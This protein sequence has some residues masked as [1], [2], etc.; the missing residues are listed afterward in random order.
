[1]QE[2]TLEIENIK[3]T[4][5]TVNV[6]SSDNKL[7]ITQKNDINSLTVAA[8]Q[9]YSEQLVQNDMGVSCKTL[10]TRL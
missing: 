3:G 4:N 1:M 10:L 6:A 7:A 9:D 8:N 5:G 2:Q